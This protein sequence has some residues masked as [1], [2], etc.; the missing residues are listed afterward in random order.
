M[1]GPNYHLVQRIVGRWAV[2]RPIVGLVALV[3][4]MVFAQFVILAG[5]VVAFFATG[6]D[7]G[8]KVDALS[9]T[10]HVTPSQLAY[11]NL[12][13]AAAIPAGAVAHPAAA[14]DASG[15][16]LLGHRP[17]PVA[18]DGGHVRAGVRGAARD[19]GGR[20]VRP[21]GR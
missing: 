2:W 6:A 18:V 21:V 16:G 17:A 8:D 20:F 9:D 10:A 7:V 12:S 13:L 4:L 19:R 15:L 5:F 14:R 11:L 3:A 1:E